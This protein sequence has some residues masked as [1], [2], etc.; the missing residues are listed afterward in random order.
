MPAIVPLEVF[1]AS[2]PLWDRASLGAVALGE[3]ESQ[4]RDVCGVEQVD[5]QYLGSGTA[6]ATRPAL[7]AYPLDSADAAMDMPVLRLHLP[8]VLGKQRRCRPEDLHD[9]ACKRGHDGERGRGEQ[10]GDQ[11]LQVA[12]GRW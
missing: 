4:E 8:S 1:V 12:A 6:V 11:G 10:V 9:A 3:E 7:E 5:A 2:E